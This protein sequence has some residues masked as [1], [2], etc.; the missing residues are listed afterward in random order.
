MPSLSSHMAIAC[1]IGDQL[2][3]NKEEFIKGN[4]LPDLYNNKIKSHFKIQGNK[5]LI[6][7]IDKAV[8]SLD[9]NSSLNLGYISHLLLDKYYFDDY[10]LKYDKDLFQDSEIY[11]DYDIINIDIIKHFRLDIDY[12]KSILK[13]F[14]EGISNKKLKNNLKC[15]EL[16]IDDDTKILNKKD[17]IK[18]LDNVVD[19][20]K[21]DLENIIRREKDG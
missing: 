4:L 3:V 9:I 18:F 8:E 16:N 17:F 11:K 13:D 21:E 7:D 19:K 14:P 6:P 15:L 20:V 10:L 2:K 5:Y 1:K 12:L